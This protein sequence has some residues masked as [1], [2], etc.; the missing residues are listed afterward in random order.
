M[1]DV[2]SFSYYLNA[3]TMKNNLTKYAQ[4]IQARLPD[5]QIFIHDV[6]GKE[7]HFKAIVVSS[8]FVGKNLVEQHRIVNDSL[9]EHYSNADASKHLGNHCLAYKIM[10][11]VLYVCVCVFL[12]LCLLCFLQVSSSRSTD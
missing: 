5:A 8:E 4:M 12:L 3:T 1:R 2:P 6:T 7:N 9:Q 10:K 11:H